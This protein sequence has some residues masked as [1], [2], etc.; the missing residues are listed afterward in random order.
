M[1]RRLRWLTD[2]TECTVDDIKAGWPE[3]VPP[4][5]VD[6]H[7]DAQ[8]E[9][10]ETLARL[11]EV[12]FGAELADP[13]RVAA[14]V[15]A[16]DALPA[17]L[18]AEVTEEAKAGPTPVPNLGGRDVRTLHLD[19]LAPLVSSAAATHRGRI[20]AVSEAL[21]GFG[22]DEAT[23]IVEWATETDGP[24]GRDMLTALQAD[25]VVALAASYRVGDLEAALLERHGSKRAV[26]DAAKTA[27]DVHGLPRPKSAADVAGDRVL[28]ALVLR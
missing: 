13:A 15:A 5:T 25:R 11:A 6:G 21:A 2:H 19:V 16:V 27:A 9:A 1:R 4:L 14:A 17:D 26:V 12:R 10:L 24:T 8:L 3:G 20:S 28:A 18:V 23:G 22:D 7:T